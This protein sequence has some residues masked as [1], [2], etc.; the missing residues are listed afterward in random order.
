M[1]V[2]E[3]RPRQQPALRAWVLGADGVVIRVEQDPER[4]I[5]GAVPGE[6]SGSSTKVSKNQLVC[7]RC[8]LTGLASG[9]D[10]IV[11]SS[12]DSGAASAIVAA[13]MARKRDASTAAV[14]GADRSRLLR[15][16]IVHRQA[17]GRG[18]VVGQIRGFDSG[19]AWK[20]AA[21]F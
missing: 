21:E 19:E 6:G 17:V 12:A 1:N 5:E 15:Q 3:R 14:G 16:A 11:Q 18:V 2:G 20:T 8:H 4:G 13:R 10:W 7:A 9:I